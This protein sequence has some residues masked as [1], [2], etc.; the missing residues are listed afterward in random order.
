[1][2]LLTVKLIKMKKTL[3]IAMCCITVLFA[4]CKKEKPYEKFIGD[5]KGSCLVEPTITVENPLIPGQTITQEVDDITLPLEVTISAG[6][7]DDQILMTYKPEGQ[8]KTYTFTGTIDKNDMVEFGT[9][10]INETYEG[11]TVNATVDMTGSLAENIFSLVGTFKGTATTALF[12][13]PVN[14]TG[15]LTGVLNKVTATK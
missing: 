5:Y 12:E 11:S 8:D 4:A 6:A 9:V 10:A 15:N 14:I 1:M 7:A 3:I 2:N 13:I